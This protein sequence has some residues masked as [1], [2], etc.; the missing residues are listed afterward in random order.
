[1]TEPTPR[2]GLFEICEQATPAVAPGLVALVRGGGAE[3]YHEAHGV[4]ALVN[5]GGRAADW[6]DRPVQRDD[7]FDLASLTK[8]LCTTILSAQLVQEGVWGLDQ[9][10]PAPCDKPGPN[11]TLAEI[12]AHCSG[13]PA[14][15]PF[16]K[17]YAW[18]SE[19]SRDSLLHRVLESPASYPAKSQSVYSDLGFITLGAAIEWQLGERLDRIFEDRIARPLGLDQ[20]GPDWVGFLPLDTPSRALPAGLDARVLPSEVYGD[21]EGPTALEGD[22]QQLRYRWAGPERWAR[23]QVHDDNAYCLLGVA[24]HAGLFGTASGVAQIAQAWLAG[25]PLG[26]EPE[27]LQRFETQVPWI[28]DKGTRCLGWDGVS[29]D[30]ALDPRAFCHLGYTGTGLWIERGDTPAIYVLL[31]HRVHTGR[32]DSQGIRE[33]RRRF[34]QAAKEWVRREDIS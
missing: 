33:L 4:R 12:L 25:A 2:Q 7:I 28:Q 5:A 18:P 27:L 20:S 13:F 11:T 30:S 9:P 32:S 34:C 29:A 24:G 17:D 10:L 19:E 3:L 16:Y 15:K 6:V 26:L 8:V 14:H 22:Y 23:G 31:S 1:M 21:P